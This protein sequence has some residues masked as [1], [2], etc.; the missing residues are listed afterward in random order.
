MT[1]AVDPLVAVVT[2]DLSAIARGRS[3]TQERLEKI[4]E[5]G[6][7]W[8]QANLSITPFN[9]I[10]SPNP[11]G[12]SG[13]LRLIPDM[14]ARFRS[15]RTGSP[16]PFDMIAGDLVEL[17]GQPWRGCT[18]TLLR[19][20]LADLKAATGLTVV[21]AFEHEFQLLG[22]DPPAAHAFSLEALRRVDPFGPS[23][24]AALEEAGIEPE[25]MI[26]EFGD[27]Q[28]EI[29]HA[30]TG[31]L[32]AADRAVAVREITREVARHLGRRATF[33][34]KTR[35]EAVG[36]GVHIHLSF[37]DEG[38][39]PAT[40][41]A[42]RPGGLSERAGQFCAGVLAHLPAITALTAASPPSYYRLVPHSWS[43]SYTWL[44]E[45]D[46]EASLRICPTVGIGGRRPEPQFNIEYRPA[47]ATAN[48][49]LALAAIV[50]AGLE[51]LEG[52]WPA[53]PLVSGDPTLMS[54]AER[55]RLGLARLPQDLSE[56][57]AALEADAT[58]RGW[59]A[60]DVLDTF[61]GLRR[62]DIARF[63]DADPADVCNRYR[64]LY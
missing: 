10:V 31:A 5:T 17:D 59:L 51:G 33:A 27:A 26:A 20:A 19:Q 30:P 37:G 25:V 61:T 56:A 58:V 64:A 35:P 60:P 43:A 8:V 57:L 45:R 23:L 21:A 29:T 55:R 36:N 22:A 42:A 49:Y 63:A 53:P 50:R 54:D 47:D 1:A 18:R 52:R 2:T 39:R 15:S 40:Y 46:R 48:P 7:G 44:A 24:I 4:A 11:W 41:D 38:G 14:E 32:A 16:T 3:V 6:L 28:F 13:D 12:S 62:D 34:P 9:S